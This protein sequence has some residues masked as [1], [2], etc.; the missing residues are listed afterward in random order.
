[1]KIY[2]R[3]ENENPVELLE[4]DLD[5]AKLFPPEMDWRD[6]SHLDPLPELTPRQTY[7]G[8][9]PAPMTIR[10]DQGQLALLDK[11]K[12]GAFEQFLLTGPDPKECRR[13]SIVFQGAIWQR[14]NPLLLAAWESTGGTPEEWIDFF[15]L[16]AKI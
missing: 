4:T 14:D 13:G 5:P 3:Y 1:M 15:V 10:G 16:A 8:P 2:A 12:L 11:N 7:A 6:V 9:A